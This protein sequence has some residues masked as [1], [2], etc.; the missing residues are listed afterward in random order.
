MVVVIYFNGSTVDEPYQTMELASIQ[1]QINLS[2]GCFYPR[3]AM[4][5]A[6][7]VDIVSVRPSV[8]LFVSLSACHKSVFC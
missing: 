2:E 6:V 3:D 7:L 8:C 4:L 1:K 5:Y